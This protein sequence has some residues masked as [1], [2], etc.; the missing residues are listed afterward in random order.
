MKSSITTL[1]FEAEIHSLNKEIQI[2]NIYKEI[3]SKYS[4][5]AEIDLGIRVAHLECKKRW[6]EKCLDLATKELEELNN[7]AEKEKLEI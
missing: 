7:W 6:A 4:I 2:N 3:C 1:A 5:D